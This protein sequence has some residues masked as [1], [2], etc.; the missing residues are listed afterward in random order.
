MWALLMHGS[1]TR[2][3]TTFSRRN[4]CLSITSVC[5]WQLCWRKPAR[6]QPR[7][8][9]HQVHSTSH[10]SIAQN[11]EFS[12]PLSRS[13]G[14]GHWPTF[15]HQWGS[16]NFYIDGVSWWRCLKCGDSKLFLCL[17]NKKQ[18]FVTYH[19]K[20]IIWLGHSVTLCG[21]VINLDKCDVEI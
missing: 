5:L 12:T 4:Q 17:N 19:Q 7:L 21:L 18:C 11:P 1:S 14:F 10:Q 13:D 20:W 15:G 2:G 9:S 3:T 8:A 6:C 16:C